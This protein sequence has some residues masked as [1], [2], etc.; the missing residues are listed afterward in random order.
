MKPMEA[1]TETSLTGSRLPGSETKERERERESERERERERENLA[2]W[3][4][5]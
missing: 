4:V 3:L 5:S 1:K 2:R